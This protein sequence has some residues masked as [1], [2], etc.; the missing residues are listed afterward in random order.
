MFFMLMMLLSTQSLADK[1]IDYVDV[2]KGEVVPFDGK[3]LKKQA[4]AKII[5]DSNAKIN[6]LNVRHKYALK[7]RELDMQLEY[8][9]LKKKSDAE[10]T[11]YEDMLS[12]RDDH[13]R[14]E[15]RKDIAQ[16]WMLYG[17]FIFGSATTVAIFHAVDTMQE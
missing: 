4:L 11:M 2:K 9:I 3:L 13:I 14:K 7:Q 6:K 1:S 5:A 10:I 17:S 8:D 16:K 12:M 15:K